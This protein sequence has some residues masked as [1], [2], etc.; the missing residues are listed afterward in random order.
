MA[1]MAAIAANATT[2]SGVDVADT[3]AS[4]AAT[5][6]VNADTAVTMPP[7]IRRIGWVWNIVPVTYIRG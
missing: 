4:H 2:S 6:A 3:W 1:T 7:S 5:V